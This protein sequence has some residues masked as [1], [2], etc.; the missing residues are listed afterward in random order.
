MQSQF[1]NPYSCCWRHHVNS[2]PMLVLCAQFDC[3]NFLHLQVRIGGA[4][5]AILHTCR[6]AGIALVLTLVQGVGEIDPPHHMCGTLKKGTGTRGQPLSS[7]SDS[8]HKSDREQPCEPLLF[9]IRCFHFNL[10]DGHHLLFLLNRYAEVTI[11]T[12]TMLTIYV[13]L[14]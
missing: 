9:C 12:L 6:V 8:N 2:H 10:L 4:P 13:S 5:A 3:S 14:W 11:W 1:N 7:T